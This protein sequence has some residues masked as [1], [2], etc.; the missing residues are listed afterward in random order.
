MT[1]FF[2]IGLIRGRIKKRKIRKK[3]RKTKRQN[4]DI[5][6]LVILGWDTA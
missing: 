3:E 6:K 2:E 1:N 5:D 4:P